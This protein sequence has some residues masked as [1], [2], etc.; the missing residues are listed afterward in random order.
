MAVW[1]HHWGPVSWYCSNQPCAEST[2]LVHHVIQPTMIVSTPVFT[3]YHGCG[4]IEA[5]ASLCVLYL[6]CCS[7]SC[8][9]ASSVSCTTVALVFSTVFIQH[10]PLHSCCM[11]DGCHLLSLCAQMPCHLRC[12]STALTTATVSFDV[13]DSIQLHIVHL[14][15]GRF[16]V[17]CHV[18]C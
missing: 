5:P 17:L 13:Q 6:H 16:S 10:Y 3:Y 11:R 7:A 2:M 14:H 4:H 1:N 15:V 12:S 8:A 9:V 18:W